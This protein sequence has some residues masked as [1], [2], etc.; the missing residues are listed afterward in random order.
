MVNAASELL[1]PPKLLSGHSLSTTIEGVIHD[2]IVDLRART[3]DAVATALHAALDEMEK[4]WPPE[5]SKYF[6]APT[7]L[8]V[9]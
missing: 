9:I 8:E 4:K 2:C 6:T 7:F 5:K 1:R 3:K